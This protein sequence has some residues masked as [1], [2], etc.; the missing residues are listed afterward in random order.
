MS[1][2]HIRRSRLLEAL[3]EKRKPIK[4]KE[5]KRKLIKK[6]VDLST[7]VGC[8]LYI[9]L[10]TTLWVDRQTILS[11]HL[12]IRRAV[13]PFLGRRSVV[14]GTWSRDGRV[15]DRTIARPSAESKPIKPQASKGQQKKNVHRALFSCICHFFFVPLQPQRCVHH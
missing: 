1:P 11:C 9:G 3:C 13:G 4:E 14:L 10:W 5:A 7:A 8:R 6:K 12:V 2:P 15:I